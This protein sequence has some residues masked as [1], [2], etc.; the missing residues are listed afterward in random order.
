MNY[1]SIGTE[2]GRVIITDPPLQHM[3]HEVT[4][5]NSVHKLNL[6]EEIQ[7]YNNNRDQIHSFQEVLNTSILSRNQVEWVWYLGGEKSRSEIPIL[8]KLLFFDT[9][10]GEVLDILQKFDSFVSKSQTSSHRGIG[11]ILRRKLFC[12]TCKNC[13]KFAEAVSFRDFAIIEIANNF[14]NHIC[15]ACNQK[16]Q[17]HLP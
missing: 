12:E 8:G 1:K 13:D 2:T 17:F 7:Y 4:I 15:A 14:S 6:M 11:Q 3:P 10:S 16:S 5:T 9:S